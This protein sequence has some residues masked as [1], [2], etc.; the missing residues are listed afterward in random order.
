MAALTPAQRERLLKLARTAAMAACRGEALPAAPTDDQSLRAP[1]A[2]FVTLE[3][4]DGGLRG[5]IGRLDATESLAAAVVAMAASAATRDPRFSP[6]T[7]D[8]LASLHIDVSALTAPEVISPLEPD[9]IE[10]GRHGLVVSR[11]ARRGVLLP[12]VASERHWSV[13]TFLE[14][15]CVK[16]GLPADAYRDPDTSVERFEAEVFGE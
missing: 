6:V 2:C 5:C 11:G 15:T 12:Q 8:E 3:L 4:P 14:Q 7:P 10:V 9:V 1:R 16:A 13:Q